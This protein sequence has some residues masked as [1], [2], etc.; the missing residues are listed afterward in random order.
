MVVADVVEAGLELHVGVLPVAV[1]PLADET[2][3]VRD[4]GRAGVGG[5]CGGVA[6]AVDG[7]SETIVTKSRQSIVGLYLYSC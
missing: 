2:L 6:T 4:G 5:G 7:G 3:E 1:D